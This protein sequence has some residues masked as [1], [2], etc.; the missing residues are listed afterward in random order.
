[1]C[2]VEGSGWCGVGEVWGTGM[3]KYAC[4]YLCLDQQCEC[5]VDTCG[6]VGWVFFCGCVK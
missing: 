5:A 1:M 6:D 3:A 4:I 2:G